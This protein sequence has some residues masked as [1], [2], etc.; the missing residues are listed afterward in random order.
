MQRSTIPARGV[1]SPYL[2]RTVVDG[3]V[4]LVLTEAV[5]RRNAMTLGFFS[6]VSHHPTSLWIS[7]A[8]T[9]LTYELLRAAG[10]FGLAVLHA[11]QGRE[12]LLCGTVSGRE[13]D[14]C[15]DLRLYRSSSGV[16]LLEDALASLA[17][18]VTREVPL[19]DHTVFIADIL[20]GDMDTRSGIR[21]NLLRSDLR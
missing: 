7:V 21:R 17:C 4:A 3:P 13:R 11:G 8:P 19:G 15:A 20:E 18:A 2:E 6:E 14:K 1:E 16:W 10:R 5:D 9:T 12:A